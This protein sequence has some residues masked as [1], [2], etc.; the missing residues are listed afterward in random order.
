MKDHCLDH[1]G[2]AH[3]IKNLEGDMIE[4]KQGT[5]KAHERID[6]IKNWVIAGMTSAILQLLGIIY[7]VANSKPAG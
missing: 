5:I 7:L 3:R 4:A 6:G 1:S 2:H